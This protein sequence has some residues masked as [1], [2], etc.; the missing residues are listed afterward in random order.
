[1]PVAGKTEEERCWTA[2]LSFS[3]ALIVFATALL[4]LGTV[5][6]VFR[7]RG[8]LLLVTIAAI[9]A[10]G[11]HPLVRRLQR[12][13]GL[14][15][16][17]AAAG[18]ILIVVL[19]V[20]PLLLAIGIPASR[21]V[22]AFFGDTNQYVYLL[23]N[24]WVE[25]QRTT[26]WLPDLTGIVDGLLGELKDRARPDGR[27]V[28]ALSLGL[29]HAGTGILTVLV[30]SCYLLLAPPR[31][32][33]WLSWLFPED[34]RPRL[35]I[36]SMRVGRRF[37]QWL[38][39]QVILSTVVG[40]ATFVGLVA[41]GV[42]YPHLLA[43]VAAVG[44]LL[45]TFGPVLAAIPAVLVAMFQSAPLTLS[46]IALAAG[47]QFLENYLIVPKVMH[48][49]VGL[50]PV[51]TII[52]LI[53]GFQLFGIAGALLAVPMV[54]ALEILVPELAAALSSHAPLSE[55]ARP[56]DTARQSHSSETGGDPR[57]QHA[58]GRAVDESVPVGGLDL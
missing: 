26:P 2:A 33:R 8:L 41:L 10:T 20:V 29:L 51:T 47:I 9:L 34:R 46:V 32:L 35:E 4:V 13:R 21:Q 19:C 39:A 28:A 55:G 40:A 25:V 53:A 3:A 48:D 54:T 58:G 17:L 27:E 1:M 45:P 23:R 31:P 22:Q 12:V 42:P 6:A 57:Q 56:G 5:Y 44:E 7:L 18:A 36:V 15:H 24:R 37:R 14:N 30:L 49:V 52:G 11:L 43:L 16:G 38:R 50:S